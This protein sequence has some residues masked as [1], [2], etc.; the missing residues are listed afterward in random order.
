MIV[1]ELRSRSFTG[2]KVRSSCDEPNGGDFMRH[3]IRQSLEYLSF[4]LAL[5]ISKPLALAHRPKRTL[6]IIPSSGPRSL[7]DEAMLKVCAD[8]ASKRNLNLVFLK[9]GNNGWSEVIG[10]GT[11]RVDLHRWFC[12]LSFLP[13]LRTSWAVLYIGADVIDGYYGDTLNRRRLYLCRLAA[14]LGVT[15]SIVNF[16]INQSPTK[17]A[18]RSLK[19]L[20]EDVGFVARDPVSQRRLQALVERTVACG[21]DLAMLFDPPSSRP[22][23]VYSDTVTRRESTLCLVPNSLLDENF[24]GRDSHAECLIRLVND[25]LNEFSNFEILMVPHD[26]L[27]GDL[28]LCQTVLGA[29]GSNRFSLYTPESHASYR[30]IVT[31]V[32]VVISCRMH[33]SIGALCRLTPT[34][35]IGYQGKVEGL[36]EGFGLEM[37]LLQPEDLLDSSEVVKT[38][39]S[40][41]LRRS[42]VRGQAALMLPRLQEAAQ[43]NFQYCDDALRQR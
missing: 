40:L 5:A 33:A 27:D 4:R 37:L 39:K 18:V 19:S 22:N 17:S 3:F 43:V 28:V 41:M 21:A 6:V 36:L 16:S 30:D 25:L 9:E 32:G 29:I 15:T 20:P 8:Y 26:H 31:D 14:A 10:V 23:P 1:Q 11:D 34:L 42:E 2:P 7:G 13:V 38:V 35:L 24:G 12:T